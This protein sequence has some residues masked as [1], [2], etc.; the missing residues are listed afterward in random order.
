VRH[1]EYREIERRIHQSPRL[2]RYDLD[3]EVFEESKDRGRIRRPRGIVIAGDQDDRRVGQRRAKA[4]ELAKGE[5]DG[6]VGRANGVKEV[7]G[8]DD[9]IGTRGD[10]AVN[11]PA[12]S[13]GNI[14][15]T[16]IESGGGLSVVLPDAEMGIGEVSELHPRNVS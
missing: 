15:F 14:G 9:G 1:G 3:A 16:L 7:S 13:Q 11:R 12:K 5:H 8:D 6:G 2:I 4:L 10:H